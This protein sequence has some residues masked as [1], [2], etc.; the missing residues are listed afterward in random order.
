MLLGNQP[1]NK[2]HSASYLYFPTPPRQPPKQYMQLQKKI[3]FTSESIPIAGTSTS[4]ASCCR[5]TD[6][7]EGLAL[8]CRTSQPGYLLFPGT[9]PPFAREVCLALPFELPFCRVVHLW[10]WAFP[11]SRNANRK[12]LRSSRELLAAH[13]P[14]F[15]QPK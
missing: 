6:R 8:P 1:S 4:D 5:D 2:Q 12:N 15:S 11:L 9:S 13:V 3:T 7:N 14:A 10:V